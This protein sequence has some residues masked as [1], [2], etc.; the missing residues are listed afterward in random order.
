[1]EINYVGISRSGEL[2]CNLRDTPEAVYIECEAYTKKNGEETYCMV[3][4]AQCS[5]PSDTVKWEG[6]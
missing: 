4:L 3:T 2:V 1:M 6:K 5:P